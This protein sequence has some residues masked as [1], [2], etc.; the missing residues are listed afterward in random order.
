MKHS[1]KTIEHLSNTITPFLTEILVEKKTKMMMHKESF[2][3]DAAQ[4][5]PHGVHSAAANNSLE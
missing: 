2:R 5:S 3:K 4:I 1:R